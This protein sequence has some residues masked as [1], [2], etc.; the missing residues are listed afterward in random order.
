M[1]TITLS[2]RYGRAHVQPLLF[3]DQCLS[4]IFRALGF[5][6]EDDRWCSIRQGRIIRM[7]CSE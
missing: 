7:G 3:L 2:F 5:D 1:Y 6:G 4:L